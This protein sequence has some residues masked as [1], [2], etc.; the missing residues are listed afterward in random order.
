MSRHVIPHYVLRRFL[1]FFRCENA[2]REGGCW[3]EDD[4][5]GV[6]LLLEWSEDG[7]GARTVI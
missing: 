6:A 4:F 2:E 1:N 5:F 3:S 7:S